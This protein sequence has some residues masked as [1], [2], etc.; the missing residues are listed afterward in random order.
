MVE[1]ATKAMIPT[2]KA[3]AGTYLQ[4]GMSPR[5]QAPTRS[6]NDA[7][8]AAKSGDGKPEAVPTTPVTPRIMQTD[9][10]FEAVKPQ[11]D[12]SATKLPP[13][14]PPRRGSRP[15]S[16]RG[17]KSSNSDAHALASPAPPKGPKRPGSGGRT[18][19]QLQ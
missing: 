17:N 18:Q 13:A 3:T 11:A 14:G 19:T 9:G 2:P 1:S 5:Q 4:P 7:G 12:D 16:A 10:K 6:E 8:R 15:L